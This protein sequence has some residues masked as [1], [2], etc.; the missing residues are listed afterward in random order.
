MSK[1]EI[2]TKDTEPIRDYQGGNFLNTLD[3]V[4]WHFVSERNLPG[5]HVAQ[6]LAQYSRHWVDY[7]MIRLRATQ[8]ENP[9][10]ENLTE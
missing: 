7:G 5:E 1:I 2:E 4:V 3:E 6:L 9:F 10:S 8:E